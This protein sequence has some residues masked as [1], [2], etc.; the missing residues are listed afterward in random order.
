MERAAEVTQQQHR[1]KS[2]WRSPGNYPWYSERR[3]A[4]GNMDAAKKKKKKRKRENRVQD[5]LVYLV[6]RIVICVVQA[7]PIDCCAQIAQFLSW[8][9]YD[10]LKIRR[11]T[12]DENLRYAFPHYSAE[13]RDQ[14][15]RGMWQHI[16]LM[17]CELAHMPRKIHDTNWRS[18]VS[19]SRADMRRFVK[20]LLDQRP[21]VV[22]SGHFGNFEVGGII[23]GLLGFPTFTVARPL[24]NPYLQNFITRFREGTGQFMLDKR[25][26]AIQIDRVLHAGETLVLLGDQAAG[27]KGCW[28]NFFGRPAS[29][30]K[31]VALFSLVNRAPMLLAYSK[32]NRQPLQFEVGV[33]ALFDPLTD[34][35]AGVKQLTQWYS[36]QLETIIRTDPSQYWWL[37]RRWK[38]KIARRGKRR[39]DPPGP[40]P[41]HRETTPKQ[42]PK[43]DAS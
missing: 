1:G 21:A 32:R 13:M 41:P 10:C 40:V 16:I 30:H 29:C 36:D 15:A 31:A 3:I 26:T 24:D 8:I 5:W 42:R 12:V 22:V 17:V 39:Q 23:A 28:V 9:C 34:E 6:L 43:I 7:L 25:G 20:Y 38:Q 14:I 35:I 33:S 19:M 11:S 2:T 27:P 4:F 18:H 37:H